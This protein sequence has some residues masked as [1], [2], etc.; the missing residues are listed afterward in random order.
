MPRSRSAA[1]RKAV[2]PVNGRG[3]RLLPATKAVPKELLPVVDRPALQYV[4][5][6]AARAGLADVLLV[7]GRGKDAIEGWFD[8][9]PELEQT[10]EKKGD[11]EGLAAVR[12]ASST[13]RAHFVRQGEPRGLG[14]AVLQAASFIGD[15]PFA[16]LLGDDIL[17]PDDR[18]LEQ[19]LAVQQE[20]GGS[21]VGLVDVG[22]EGVDRYG[23]VAAEPAG[24]TVVRVTGLVEK[25]HVDEA[26]STL[27]VIGR[28]V[29]APEVFDALR[30]TAPG[31]GDEIQLTDALAALVARGEPVHGV[32]LRGRRYDIGDRLGYLQAVVRLA[33][34]RDDI[35]PQLRSWLRELVSDLPADSASPS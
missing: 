18:F 3:T 33:A 8:T 24:G 16:V 30:R 32:V 25:P 14:H 22:P 31:H 21:V 29:L 28:Y 2:V 11:V 1:A 19:M 17:D 27:A 26:P 23:V 10:L 5:E 12:A 20:R 6:E 35:G 4:V 7:T 13:V 34:E 9:H 15:E